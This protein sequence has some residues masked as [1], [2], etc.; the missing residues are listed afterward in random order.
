M[1]GFIPDGGKREESCE[2]EPPNK[3]GGGGGCGETDCRT[4]GDSW[5]IA[6][7]CGAKETPI[8]M[9]TNK[10]QLL[11]LSEVLVQMLLHQIKNNET[12]TTKIF[13]GN[14][15]QSLSKYQKKVDAIRLVL[16]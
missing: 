1:S 7:A 8:P 16:R 4:A 13:A 5:D 12:R 15:I 11:S 9:Q 3:G 14:S 6:K 10:K 2:T